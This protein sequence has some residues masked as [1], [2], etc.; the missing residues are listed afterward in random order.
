MGDAYTYALTLLARRELCEA[1]IRNR[2]EQKHYDLPEIDIA[3]T[4]LRTERALDDTRTARAFT[5]TETKM[6]N[7]SKQ[8]I[9]RRLHRLGITREVAEDA[10]REVFTDLDERTLLEAT[11]NRRL[12]G[13]ASLTD[14]T[15]Q[16][17]LHRYLIGQGFDTDQVVATLRAH[18]K[19]TD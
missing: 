18:I 14:P 12:R 9:L 7:R 11:L 4:R 15:V 19:S 1:Q 8:W 3:I 10:V 5:R 17:R 13:G 2:L 16:R 6:R